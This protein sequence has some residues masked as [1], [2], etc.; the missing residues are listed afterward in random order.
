[1]K[2]TKIDGISHKKYNKKGKLIKSNDIA[3]PISKGTKTQ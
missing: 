3:P 2:V 1:M